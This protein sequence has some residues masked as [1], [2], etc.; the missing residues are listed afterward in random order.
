MRVLI[1]DDEPIVLE[2]IKIMLLD[3]DIDGTLLP[4]TTEALSLLKSEEFDEL[5]IILTDYNLP[6][7]SGREWIKII[8]EYYPNIK[9]V[10]MSGYG[11]LANHLPDDITFLPKPFNRQQLLS[12][13]S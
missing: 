10:V 3:S 8:R 4:N 1:I 7:I 9:L 2:A 11:V 6:N 12:V 13:L 5:D